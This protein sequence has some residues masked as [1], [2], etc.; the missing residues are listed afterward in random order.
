MVFN[1]Y[2]DLFTLNQVSKNTANVYRQELTRF[3]K[4]VNNRNGSVTLEQIL[5]Y[6]NSLTKLHPIT[7]AWKMSVIR[8]FFSFLVQE[9]V[10]A[11]N[12]AINVKSPRVRRHPHFPSFALKQFKILINNVDKTTFRGFRD[13]CL[14]MC[15]GRLGMRV[16]EVCNLSHASFDN[17]ADQPT[18]LIFGKGNAIRTIPILDKF[19]DV[20]QDYLQYYPFVIQEN[21]PLFPATSVTLRPLTTRAIQKIIKRNCLQVGIKGNITLHTLRHF[22]LSRL[23]TEGRDIFTIQT[24]AGHSQ[25][26]TTAR[27]LHNLKK[28]KEYTMNIVHKKGLMRTSKKQQL[29]LRMAA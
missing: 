6:R 21:Y 15:M 14:F 12:P 23:L 8:S 28:Q 1:K 4:H 20:L 22:A 19:S 16:S 17:D 13:Y 2:I 7:I 5:Q 10:I 11:Q 3:F 29:S 24:F 27:Y 25:L 9:Q 18:F 26:A